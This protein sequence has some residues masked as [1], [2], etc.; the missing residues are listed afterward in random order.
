MLAIVGSILNIL[1]IC[2]HF[3]L[4]LPPIS[5]EPYASSWSIWNDISFIII[6][7]L[8]SIPFIIQVRKNIS[9]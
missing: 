7:G 9:L 2:A 8:I 6:I 1:T 3:L 4:S 5:E